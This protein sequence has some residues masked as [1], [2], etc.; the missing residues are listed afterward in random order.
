MQHPVE[1]ENIEE[2]RRRE[3]IDDAQLREA[4]RGL[5]VGDRVNLTL[6][7]GRELGGG[8]TL[9]VRITRIRGS[10][11]RGQLAKSPSSKALSHLQAGSP[12]TFRRDHIH[13]IPKG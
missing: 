3:G 1:V 6:L 10:A 4:I 9:V 2:M 8:E 5:R 11:F 7:T 12:V 13:S